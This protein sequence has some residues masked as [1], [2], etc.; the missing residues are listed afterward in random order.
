MTGQ[1]KHEWPTWAVIALVKM[2]HYND[3]MRIKDAHLKIVYILPVLYFDDSTR[4]KMDSK[5]GAINRRRFKAKSSKSSRCV[6]F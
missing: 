6:S 2:E 1:A 5:A 4:V 3:K